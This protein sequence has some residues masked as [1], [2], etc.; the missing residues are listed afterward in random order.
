[1]LRYPFQIYDSDRRAA[2]KE[3][4]SANRAEVGRRFED[5]A[6]NGSFQLVGSSAGAVIR[7]RLLVSIRRFRLRARLEASVIPFPAPATSHA[8][9]GFPALRAPA[10]FG[11]RVMRL[12]ELERLPAGELGNRQ[13]DRVHRKTTVDPIAS[14]RSPGAAEL[15]PSDAESFPRPS[16]ERMR[17]IDSHVR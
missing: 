10:H 6:H 15:W 8:A 14:S 1:M 9:C 12:I 4:E 17:N 5:M 16:C 13:T 7:R 3:V 2:L 11:S